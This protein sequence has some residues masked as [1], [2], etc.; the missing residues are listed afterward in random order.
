MYIDKVLY[1]ARIHAIGGR[2]NGTVH[3][4][5]NDRLD[6][7]TS[8]PGSVGKGTNPEQLFAAGWSTCLISAVKAVAT[9]ARINVPS[10][11][12]IDAEVD[13]AMSEGGHVL[14]ARFNFLLPGMDQATA[15]ALVAE[16]RQICPYSKAT[17]GNINVEVKVT[18]QVPEPLVRPA[19]SESVRVS[20]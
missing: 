3:S 18:T 14:Q 4:L 16:A 15:E 17:H 7:T 5:D 20:P 13:L 8:V 6:L 12:A 10:E 19:A 2:A 9:R 11:I 1:T